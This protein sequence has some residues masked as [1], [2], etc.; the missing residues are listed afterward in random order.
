MDIRSA[1]ES[2]YAVIAGKSARFT[3]NTR[4]ALICISFSPSVALPN[5]AS[6]FAE[7][8]DPLATQFS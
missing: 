7:A 2:L 8:R 1:L 6:Y 3:S 5:A 4:S